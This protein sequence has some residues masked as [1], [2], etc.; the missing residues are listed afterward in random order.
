MNGVKTVVYPFMTL[1]DGTE[2][3][4]SEMKDDGSVKV[5]LY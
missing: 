3:F 1:D 4:H 2:I 5:Y